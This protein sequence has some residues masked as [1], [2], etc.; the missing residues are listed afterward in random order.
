MERWQLSTRIRLVDR[1]LGSRAPR[2]LRSRGTGGL[3][4]RIAAMSGCIFEVWPS[5]ML[6]YALQCGGEARVL[7]IGA[8]PVE[9]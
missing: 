4:V 8:S 2:P 6:G 3:R 7:A 1:E 9:T 5:L